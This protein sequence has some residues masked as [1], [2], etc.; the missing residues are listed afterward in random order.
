[1]QY[2]Q[3]SRREGGPANKYSPDS[4]AAVDQTETWYKEMVGYVNFDDESESESGSLN[5]SA[6][7]SHSTITACVHSQDLSSDSSEEGLEE[8]EGRRRPVVDSQLRSKDM[9]N[10]LA[11]SEWRSPMPTIH[12]PW[13]NYTH[14]PYDSYYHASYRSF[15]ATFIPSVQFATSSSLFVPPE[16][17]LENSKAKQGTHQLSKVGRRKRTPSKC[18]TKRVSGGTGRLSREEEDSLPSREY[19]ENVIRDILNIPPDVA[20]KDAWP[21]AVTPWVPYGKVNALMLVLCCSENT[22]A[23]VKEIQKLLVDKY[24][25]LKSTP[26]NHGWRRTLCGYLSHL[27]QFRRIERE[28]NKG[29]Y[30]VLNVTKIC[31]RNK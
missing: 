28:G 19:T 6:G 26:S 24:P 8:I 11:H 22:R 12:T 1:M 20:I 5:D 14:Y 23:T 7:P 3:T 18:V 16:S 29:D 4:D 21:T 13:H 10:V 15:G 31:N 2:S 30:W 27:P 17:S 9:N 25:A